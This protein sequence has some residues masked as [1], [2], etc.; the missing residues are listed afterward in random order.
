MFGPDFVTFCSNWGQ[1]VIFREVVDE[2][3]GRDGSL[4]FFPSLPLYFSM[5]SGSFSACP[6]KFQVV[7]CTGILPIVSACRLCRENKRGMTN[8]SPKYLVSRFWV[9]F[10]TIKSRSMA[11]RLSVFGS[12]EL[13]GNWKAVVEV[14]EH[15]ILIHILWSVPSRYSLSSKACISGGQGTCHWARVGRMFWPAPNA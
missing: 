2:I 6:I 11:L 14:T 10:A 4:N 12:L 5:N 1:N 15:S 3:Y 13:Y 8:S 9:V 7:V